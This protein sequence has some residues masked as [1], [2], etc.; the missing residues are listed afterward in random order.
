MKKER[1]KPKLTIIDVNSD[2]QNGAILAL[3]DTALGS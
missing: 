2:T 3:I 1:Q